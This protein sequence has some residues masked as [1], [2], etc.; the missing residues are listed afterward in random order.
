MNLRSLFL[1]H[2]AQTSDAPMLLEIEKG[3][4]VYLL[5]ASGKSYIDLISGISVSNLGH[6]HPKVVEA[7]ADQASKYAH[8]LVYGEFVMSPQ[9][10][11]ATYLTGLLPD[12]LNVV[13]FTNSGSEAVEGALKLAKKYTGRSNT[14]SC[15]NAYHGS[16]SGAMALMGSEE[17]K[18]GYRPLIPGNRLIEYNNYEDLEF[19]DESVACV[20]MEVVQAEAGVILPLSG[21]LKAVRQRCDEVGALLVFDEIQTGLGRTGKLFAFEHYNV[22]PD[23]ILL[24]KSL[25]GGLPLGA[26]IASSEI[27]GVLSHDPPLGHITTF[28]GN[29][30]CCAAALA[31]IKVVCDEKLYDVESKTKYFLDSL[32][33]SAIEMVRQKGLFMAIQLDEF[34]N[35]KKV[36]DH[37]LEKGLIIDWFLFADD[38]LRLAPPLIISEDQIAV[39]CQKI[40]ESLSAVYG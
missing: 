9:V 18:Q 29:A 40:N 8:T 26:F 15:K 31:A 2:V 7:I 22:K 27:M 24:A 11:L 20:V 3:E 6:A 13:Y 1:R 39:A 28:G 4:G 33:H 38:C 12:P 17:F 35:V 16:S 30:I 32:S 25:G 14:I 21:Y 10:E 5:D 37:A 23:I 19:I 36:I 34:K